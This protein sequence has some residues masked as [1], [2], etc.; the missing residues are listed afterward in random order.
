MTSRNLHKSVLVQSLL[1]LLFLVEMVGCFPSDPQLSYVGVDAPGA[2][3]LLDNAHSP[4]EQE[5]VVRKIET[6]RREGFDWPYFWTQLSVNQRLSPYPKALRRRLFVLAAHS[7]SSGG[8]DAFADL[9]LRM[10]D[11]YDLVTGPNRACAQPLSESLLSKYLNLFSSRLWPKDG[12]GVQAALPTGTPE[13]ARELAE[14]ITNEYQ[15]RPTNQ[16]MTLLKSLSTNQW[17]TLIDQLL[18]LGEG[19]LASELVQAAQREYGGIQFIDTMILSW[20]SQPD[21]FQQMIEKNELLDMAL[22]LTSDDQLLVTSQNVTAQ[23]WQPIFDGL[24]K[25]FIESA[26]LKSENFD[27]L[28]ALVQVLHIFESI[29]QRLAHPPDAAALL[30]WYQRMLKSLEPGL[31]T[32]PEATAQWMQANDSDLI[33][34]WLKY[35]LGISWTDFDRDR[36]DKMIAANFLEEGLIKKLRLHV[37]P[38][39]SQELQHG[40]AAYCQWLE[41]QGIPRRLVSGT[42]FNWE[43]L[44]DPGCVELKGVQA[45]SDHLDRQSAT[46][47]EM[48]FDS[49]LISDGWNL[50]LQ[51][52]GFDGSFLDLSTTLRW[53]DLPPEPEPPQDDAVAFPLLMGLGIDRGDILKGSGIYYFVYH[54]TWRAAQAGRPAEQQPQTGYSGADFDLTGANPNSVHAPTFVS[55]GGLGQKGVPP[56]PGG[57]SSPS[58]VMWSTLAESLNTAVGFDGKSG[59]KPFALPDP[60]VKILDLLFKNGRLDTDQKYVL[61]IEPDRLLQNITADQIAKAN[62]A[63]PPSP[64][65]MDCWRQ[66]T[67]LAAQQLHQ[68][69]AS[70]CPEEN[71]HSTCPENVLQNVFSR[72]NSAYFVEAAGAQG[73]VN[74]DGPQGA[75]G[76]F[77]YGSVQ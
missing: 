35:R 50:N 39:T 3:S 60:T 29:P 7:C 68:E 5:V 15:L 32:T 75:E 62:M 72:L 70:V 64:T 14:L 12:Q 36:L 51:A 57:R 55:L 74:P 43:I 46:P 17:S 20:V 8:F 34:L 58:E 28:L 69:F 1:P 44:T 53:P 9:V 77:R 41:Q 25:R 42:N 63:C 2:I 21:G 23:Q 18:K 38:W 6:D 40:F 37:L 48:S 45:V 65:Q 59:T 61:Y 49:V 31:A 16:R 26:T 4:D 24:Q 30:I 22:L 19:H 10:D 54:Y 66:L 13:A 56:R 71:D 47:V 52:P 33:A 73:P 76:H 67:L 11:G 27:G